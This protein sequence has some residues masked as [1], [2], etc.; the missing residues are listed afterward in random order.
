MTK[1]QNPNSFTFRNFDF[2]PAKDS[3]MHQGRLQRP[4]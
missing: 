1:K 4:Q 3:S 2:F